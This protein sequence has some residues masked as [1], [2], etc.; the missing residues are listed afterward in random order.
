MFSLRNKKNMDYPPYP[1]LSGALDS[2]CNDALMIMKT[3]T[4]IKVLF[5]EILRMNA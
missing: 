3:E 2:N 4:E 5:K 1:L